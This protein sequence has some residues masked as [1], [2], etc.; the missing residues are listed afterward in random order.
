MTTIVRVTQAGKPARLFATDAQTQTQA[1]YNVRAANAFWDRNTY[2]LRVV[3]A[4][5]PPSHV[6]EIS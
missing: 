4:A 2:T 6:I 3:V 1:L 5:L